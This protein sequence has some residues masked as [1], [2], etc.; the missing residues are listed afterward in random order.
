M[1]RLATPADAD[2]CLRI[3]AP[4]IERTAI[5]FELV[6]PTVAEFAARIEKISRTY[7]YLVWQDRNEILG[8]VY[9]TRY[10]E[11]AAYDWICESAIYLDERAQGKGIGKRLYQKLFECLRAMHM[12]SVVG[13]IRSGSPSAEFHRHMGFKAV[14]CIP[15]SG[16][17]F[18]EWHDVE[19]W[20][21][22][23]RDPVPVS[24]EPVKPFPQVAELIEFN[25]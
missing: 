13:G 17:K 19:F 20:Q 12:I 9:A 2:A 18:G 15:Y 22:L 10:R 11:R 7:P 21:F 1:I 24:P 3:Y 16:F 8:F 4:I 5:S 6:T 25:E 14:G 23:L